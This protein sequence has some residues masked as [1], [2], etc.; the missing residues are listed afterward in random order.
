MLLDAGHRDMHSMRRACSK[1]MLCLLTK[2]RD[3]RPQ[4]HLEMAVTKGMAA[5]LDLRPLFLLLDGRPLD[6]LHERLRVQGQENVLEH[7][8]CPL[9]RLHRHEFGL[10]DTFRGSF[11]SPATMA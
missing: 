7:I 9:L 6:N 2:H 5:N 11:A 1:N 3:R 8:W 10:K 4:S